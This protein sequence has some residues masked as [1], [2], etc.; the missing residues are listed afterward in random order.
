[1]V[2]IFLDPDIRVDPDFAK[3]LVSAAEGRGR[4]A[5]HKMKDLLCVQMEAI[6]ALDLKQFDDKL[7]QIEIV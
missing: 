7:D 5:D 1:M 2:L 4:F 6:K 3:K